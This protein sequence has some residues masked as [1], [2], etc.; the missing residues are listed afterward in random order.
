VSAKQRIVSATHVLGHPPSA[1]C[2]CNSCC[3]SCC[4]SR[5]NS[6]CCDSC[7]C[8][9]SCCSSC[10]NSCCYDCCSTCCTQAAV[11]CRVLA[12]ASTKQLSCTCAGLSRVKIVFADDHSPSRAVAAARAAAPSMMTQ[13]LAPC[14]GLATPSSCRNPRAT[15][16]SR[17]RDSLCLVT[18]QTQL[19]TI[20]ERAGSSTLRGSPV[21][22]RK[23]HDRTV[24]GEEV[25]PLGSI[26]PSPPPTKSERGSLLFFGL[27]FCVLPFF[28]FLS[29]RV[30]FGGRVQILF[31][32]S[33]LFFS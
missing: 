19:A 18:H 13:S 6:C 10:W 5:C 12:S 30:F 2:C 3:C 33:F 20:A 26:S 21:L 24:C 1:C 7:C 27:A 32:F 22:E 17:R 25:P 14:A 23:L 8:D 29:S 4:C 28:H 15:A 11:L 9:C 16:R 31:P